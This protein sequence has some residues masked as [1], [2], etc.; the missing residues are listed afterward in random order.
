M[1]LSL[2]GRQVRA[3]QMHELEN[4]SPAAV[5][6]SASGGALPMAIDHS[7]PNFANSSAMSGRIV[8]A[9]AKS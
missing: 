1:L 8:L 5:K 3:E 9:A 4:T 6:L 7:M 2:L